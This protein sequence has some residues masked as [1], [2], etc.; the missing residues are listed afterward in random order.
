[1]ADA[2]TQ[3]QLEKQNTVLNDKELAK[4]LDPTGKIVTPWSIRNWRLQG[5]LPS[6][7]VGNRIFFRLESVLTWMDNKETGIQKTETM[8]YGTLRKI[9]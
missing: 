3:R 6:F 1:M 8:Q 4:V 9:D 2:Q 7:R 5:G